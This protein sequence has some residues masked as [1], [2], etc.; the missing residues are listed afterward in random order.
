MELR[1]LGEFGLIE[2]IERAARKLGSSR[3]VLIGIGD[4]G[5]TAL[6]DTLE[7]N[8]TMTKLWLRA[9]PN[10]YQALFAGPAIAC[11]VVF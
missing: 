11:E 5:A 1:E 8:A 10:R 9:I 3:S 6:A 7:H 2:R 4:D